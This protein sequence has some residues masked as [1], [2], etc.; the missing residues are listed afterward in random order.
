MRRISI[1]FALSTLLLVSVTSVQQTATT[2]Q[3]DTIVNCVGAKNGT[4]PIW[5]G[6]APPNIT[7]CNSGIYEASPYGT[8]AIGILNPNPIG[9]V[10][11]RCSLSVSPVV[12]YS[13]DV[14]HR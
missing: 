12:T 14:G 8:G 3:P 7:L 10:T 2:S 5:T 6:S 11:S 1:A 9:E 4:I 13:C